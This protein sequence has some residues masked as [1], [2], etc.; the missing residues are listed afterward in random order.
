MIG[1]IILFILHWYGSLFFQTFFLHRYASHAMFTMSRRWEK[2]FHVLTW[3][4]QGTSY[5]SPYAYGVMHRMHH[6]H[7]DTEND[8]HSPIFDKNIWNMMWKTRIYYKE[9]GTG[10]K[11]IEEKYIKGVPAWRSWD[12]FAEHNLIRVAWIFVYIGLYWL[13]DAPLW[14]YFVFIPMHALMSPLHGAI[15]N[16]FSHKY[17]YRNYEVKDTST[18]LMPVDWL[19]WGECLHNNHHKFGGR[20]NFAVK[21]FEFDPMFPC[22]RL[23]EKLNIIQFK[24]GKLDTDY[25]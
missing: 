13:V 4:F 14:A 1:V 7:A 6:K 16:W 24:K 9:V 17:G 23:M 22:I 12:K 10:E 15:V 20:P 2:I 11:Q 3:I 5:L 18:N 21:K 8:P 19:M 25:M